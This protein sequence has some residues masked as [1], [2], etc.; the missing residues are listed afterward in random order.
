[1]SNDSLILFGDRFIE[2]LVRIAE[3]DE[4]GL[5]IYRGM[6]YAIYNILNGRIKLDSRF[7]R[8]Q[9]FLNLVGH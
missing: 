4:R 7:E 3:R 9:Q 1:M 2:W 5:G 6:F 8:P